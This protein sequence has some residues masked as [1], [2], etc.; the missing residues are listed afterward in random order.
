MA[1]ILKNTENLI[2]PAKLECGTALSKLENNKS[3][4]TDGLT[5]NSFGQ[6]SKA[7][8]MKVIYIVK[9]MAHYDC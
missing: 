5:T 4:G 3:Q 7:Y 2:P 1:A 6:I 8:Y 9:I